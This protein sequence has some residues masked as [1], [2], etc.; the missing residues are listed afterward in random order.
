MGLDTGSFHFGKQLD[1]ITRLQVLEIYDA[2]TWTVRSFNNFASVADT[3]LIIRQPDC[4]SRPTRHTP[5]FIDISS[6]AVT[7]W[8]C[9]FVI[10]A[11]RLLPNPYL[12][13]IQQHLCP[14]PL[15]PQR[16]DR[17]CSKQ[18]QF[19]LGAAGDKT[20]TLL[21]RRPAQLVSS[22]GSGSQGFSN[23]QKPS[24]ARTQG[25]KGAN[26]AKRKQ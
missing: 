4:A 18:S 2:F 6:Q 13:P 24:F 5:S 10:P 22:G 14:V 3:S 7:C 20:D 11:E 15:S 25:K 1:K 9:S 26:R 12:L 8:S 23:E 19:E 16:W 21:R 17:K